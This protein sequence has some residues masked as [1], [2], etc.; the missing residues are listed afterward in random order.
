M[1]GQEIK[2]CKFIEFDSNHSARGFFFV[3]IIIIIIF[4]W[5]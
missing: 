1:F 5:I 4:L 3:I 2:S